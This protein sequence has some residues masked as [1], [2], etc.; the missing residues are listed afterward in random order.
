[1]YSAKYIGAAAFGL[2]D[3]I[4][5]GDA[6]ASP[7]FSQRSE[8]FHPSCVILS[9]DINTMPLTGIHAKQDRSGLGFPFPPEAAAASGHPELKRALIS[10]VWKKLMEDIDSV[11]KWGQVNCSRCWPSILER[12]CPLSLIKTAMSLWRSPISLI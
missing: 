7:V 8:D 6:G 10:L 9:D 11:H 4:S 5:C 12:S 3:V 2:R 1:M